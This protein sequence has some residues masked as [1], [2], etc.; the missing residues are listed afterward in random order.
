[1]SLIKLD[2]LFW[3]QLCISGGG[4]QKIKR[5]FCFYLQQTGLK[6]KVGFSL[7]KTNTEHHQKMKHGHSSLLKII[8]KRVLMSTDSDQYQISRC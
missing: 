2:N 8:D 7:R 1:M 4:S 6:V 5:E 3:W